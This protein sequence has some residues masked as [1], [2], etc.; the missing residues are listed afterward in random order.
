MRLGAEWRLAGHW[1]GREE[2]RG[3][4][5][6]WIGRGKREEGKE[7]GMERGKRGGRERRRKE[8]EGKAEER[9]RKEVDRKVEER[10]KGKGPGRGEIKEENGN[11]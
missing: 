8:V 7:S 1:E 2:G 4:E 6:R 11:E 5:R 3:G 10:R 9:R